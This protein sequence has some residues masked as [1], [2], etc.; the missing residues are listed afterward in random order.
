M[1][2]VSILASI[3]LSG[4]LIGF[5]SCKKEDPAVALEVNQEQAATIQGK[6]LINTNE[7]D[8][9]PKWSAAPNVQIVATV[10]YYQLNSNASGTYIIKDVVYNPTTGEFSIKA[11]VGAN[12][13]SVDVKFNDFKTTVIVP[14]WVDTSYVDKTIRVIW[15]GQSTSTPDLMPG[16]VYTL[17]T[18]Q[19]NGAGDYIK[20]PS[21]GEGI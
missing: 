7:S 12:G 5:T 20:D 4:L 1:K 11:P 21:V 15:Q 14:E 13:S 6:I 8:T 3:A 19:L 17:P 9:L 18:W 10:P 16:E 2:K